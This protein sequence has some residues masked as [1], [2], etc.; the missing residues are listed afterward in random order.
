MD[1]GLQTYTIRDLQKKDMDAAYK[2]ASDV[3]I[4]YFEVA[5]IKFNRENADRVKRI[6]EKYGIRVMSA[7]VKPKQVF[8]DVDGVVEFCK[9]TGCK[10]V[11]ISMLPFE[12][13]LGSDE[14]FYDF[15]KTLDRQTEIYAKHGLTLAYHHHNWEYIKLQNGLTRMDVLL[16]ETKKIMFVH[17]TYWTARSGIS[18]DLQIKR[19]GNRLL[20]VH[21]RDLDFNKKLLDVIPT[22]AP[23]GRGVIDFSKVLSACDEVGCSYYV[24]EQNSPDPKSDLSF[25]L[26]SLNKIVASITK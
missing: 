2:M 24:I 26:A 21:L 9:I 3:G 18:P 20:G 25:S 19:F 23:I 11:V 12:C 14:K 13:I 22:D 4:K 7:Q 6:T 15:I 10:N 8:G 1:F 5:R 16:R 17:D